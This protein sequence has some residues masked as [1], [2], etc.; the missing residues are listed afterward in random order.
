MSVSGREREPHP[1]GLGKPFY[2]SV[3]LAVGGNHQSPEAWKLAARPRSVGTMT[4]QGSSGATI[5]I[6]KSRGAKQPTVAVY[7]M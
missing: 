5:R 3:I 7:T 6:Q 2:H 1:G 4:S